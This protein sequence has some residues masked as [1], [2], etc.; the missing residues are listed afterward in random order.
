MESTKVL[1]RNCPKC[2]TVLFKQESTVLC[3]CGL[4]LEII[5]GKKQ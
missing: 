3:I 4:R 2:G 1:A 5:D